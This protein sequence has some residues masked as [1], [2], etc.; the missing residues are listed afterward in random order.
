MLLSAYQTLL[1]CRQHEIEREYAQKAKESSLQPTTKRM[2]VFA[3]CFLKSLD[4]HW[5]DMTP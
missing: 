1:F 3:T 5:D 2:S 4:R